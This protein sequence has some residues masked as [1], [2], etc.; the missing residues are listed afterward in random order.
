MSV[1]TLAPRERTRPEPGPVTA[2]DVVGSGV[3]SAAGTG[4]AAFA[5]PAAPVGPAAA[6]IADPAAF[7][8]VRMRA[9]P[10][11]D[12]AGLLGRKGLRT[13]DR[14]GLLGL[15]AAHL[16]LASAVGPDPGSARTGVVLGTGVGGI[17]SIGE[18]GWDTRTREL[19]HLV[20]PAVFPNTMLN[21]TAGQIAIRNKLTGVNATVA[22]GRLAGLAAIRFARTALL[23]GRADRLLVG[24]AEEL[25]PQLAWGL[26][27]AGAVSPRV[28]VGE[29]AALFA[30]QPAEPGSDVPVLARLL[31]AEVAHGQPEDAAT[32]LAACAARALARSGVRP[33][34]VGVL[35]P[36]SAGLPGLAEVELAGVR[37]ALGGLPAER[38]D[39][40]P[41]LG[42]TYSATAALHLAGLL[43]RWRGGAARAEGHVTDE[44]GLL[45]VVDH[46]GGVGCLVV[47][48]G[49]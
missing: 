27:R 25:S 18:F 35:V 45:T 47:R 12:A 21:Y 15:V 44:V 1:A 46:G 29:G 26:R 28:G 37:A 19:P 10:D 43:A 9:V 16:A 13:V 2:L 23:R 39:V 5:D 24:A 48:S 20:N 30:V 14:T 40:S 36:G 42:E 4:L 6:G 34:Q 3:V 17:R 22:G 32:L 11:L 7:P 41:V 49:S 8:P 38:V 31:A 33:E